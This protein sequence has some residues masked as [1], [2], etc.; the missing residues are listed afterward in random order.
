MRGWVAG[1]GG[2]ADQR[3]AKCS[4]KVAGAAAMTNWQGL[5]QRDTFTESRR[6]AYRSPP[7]IAMELPPRPK[8]ASQL[9]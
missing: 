4:S 8:I 9:F 5:R 1:R 7:A 6:T 3:G 2:E